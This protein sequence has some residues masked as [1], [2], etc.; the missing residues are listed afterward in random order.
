MA[1]RKETRAIMKNRN[2]FE[3]PSVRAKRI[4][5]KMAT[6]PTVH[7]IISSINKELFLIL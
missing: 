7:Q 2:V 3:P 6:A 5:L 1:N 4:P